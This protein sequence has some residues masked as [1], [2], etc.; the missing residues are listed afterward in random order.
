MRLNPL[1]CVFEVASGKFLGYMVNQ[2]GIE[3]NTEKIKVM[4]KPD[5]SGRPLK[6]A[7]EL[8]QFD[9]VF[10]PRTAIKGQAHTNFVVEFANTLEI[11]APWDP[12]NHLRGAFSST[13]PRKIWVQG[14]E[15]SSPV[16][17]TTR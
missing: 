6:W 5:T 1:K 8:S 16:P 12:Q 4:Q 7:V 3:A 10:K 17:K 14:P 9:I 11:D 15:W 2:K 13:D